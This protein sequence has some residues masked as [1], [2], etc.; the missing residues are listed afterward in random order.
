MT[1]FENALQKTSDWLNIPGVE[2]II[3][4]HVE[5]SIMVLISCSPEKI[6]EQIP[7]IF[8]GFFVNIYYVQGLSV[9]HRQRT[10]LEQCL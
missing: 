3:P 2:T 5:Q 9:N 10:S 6:S 1:D 7:T 8:M 4:D